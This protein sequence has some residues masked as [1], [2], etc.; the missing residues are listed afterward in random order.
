MATPLSAD[1]FLAALRDEGCKVVE[2]DGWRTHTRTSSGRPWGPVHGI[3]IHHTV[4][5]GT[6]A[7]VRI[8]REGYAGLPGP[9]CHGVIAKDGTIHLVGYGRTNHAGG[10]DPDVLAAVTD[11]SYGTR[12]PAPNV[13][14]TDGTDGNRAFYGFECENLGDGIDPWP[15]VQLDAI[16]R[17][18][19]AL[20]R[21]HSWGAK[22]VIGHLEWSD[23][24][25]DPRGFTMPSMRDRVAARLSKPPNAPAPS[26]PKPT[27][28]ENSVDLPNSVLD[29]IALRVLTYRNRKADEASVKATKRRIP[30]FYGYV[31]GTYTTVQGIAAD[32]K[33]V[34]ALLSKEK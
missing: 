32:L 31:V 15:A 6:D 26:T 1:R 16:E 7:T 2:H 30:D 22:S 11:E 34:I 24:K 23:D 4:S 20:S 3:V 33:K 8:C 25:S 19:A 29:R 14:N 5:K 13:G 9:L 28:E 10:G 18:S 17:A 27:P 21:A 12:P